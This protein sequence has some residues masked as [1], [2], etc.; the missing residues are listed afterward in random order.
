[1]QKSVRGLGVGGW[2]GLGFGVESVKGWANS[3]EFY[4]IWFKAGVA[5]ATAS[6]F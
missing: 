3:A 1:M 6:G 5:E 4:E 2:A